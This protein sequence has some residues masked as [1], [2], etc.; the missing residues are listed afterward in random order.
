MT[1]LD[2][3]RF[4]THLLQQAGWKAHLTP[5]GSDQGAD[6]IAT[7]RSVRLVVQ[8]K[9]YNRPVGNRAVQEIFTAC[10]HQRGNLAA[11]VSNAGYTR[12]A[13]QLAESTGVYLLHHRQLEELDETTPSAK[14]TAFL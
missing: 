5:N 11:V 2:Y 10:Q 4:C 12:H 7:R 6:I 9:L 14:Q 13:R 3:E 1:P 8:C